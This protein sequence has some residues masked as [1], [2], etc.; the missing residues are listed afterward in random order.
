MRRGLVLVPEKRE[1]FAS[2]SVADNLQLGGFARDASAAMPRCSPMCTRAFPGLPSAASNGR[3][4]CRAAS[5]RCW[6]SG[7]R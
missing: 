6:R 3:A 4:R 5:G 2:M 1:L 7:E